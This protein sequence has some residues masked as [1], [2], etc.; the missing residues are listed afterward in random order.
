M[1]N[2]PEE[3]VKCDAIGDDLIEFALGTLSGRRRSVVL[4]HLET[5][6]HCD[7]ESEALASV[8]DSMLWL[9][10]EAEPPLG[11]ESRLIER[12]R[13]TEVRHAS[14]SSRRRRVAVFALAAVLV[15]V[16]GIGIDAIVMSNERTNNNLATSRPL[17]G[18]LMADGSV[19]GQVS[20]SSGHPS[21]MIM[22]VDAG[23]LSGAVW[24]EV[25]F[26][27]GR[28]ETVGSF[29]LANGYGS[30]I[31]AIKDSGSRVRSARLV[32]SN[33]KVLA[34]ATFAV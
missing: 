21:W 14:S 34:M 23:Y 10:P 24:C 6:A 4:D 27:N 9:A 33:G 5:C 29:T 19:V 32:N 15:A 30:W 8:A 28:V 2:T 16:L 25:T 11:F 3:S 31:A 12:Y 18:H 20:I 1:S 7:A 17:T 13:S 26:A 22:D